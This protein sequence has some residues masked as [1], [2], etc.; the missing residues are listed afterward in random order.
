MENFSIDVDVPGTPHSTIVAAA[1]FEKAGHLTKTERVIGTF[2]VGNVVK[3]VDVE[4]DV[5]K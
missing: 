3:D 5:D 2:P 1:A 4:R